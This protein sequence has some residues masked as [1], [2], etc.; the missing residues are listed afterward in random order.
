MFSGLLLILIIVALFVAKR[1]N[2]K[3]DAAAGEIARVRAALDALARRVWRADEAPAPVAAE[4]SPPPPPAPEPAPVVVA[5]PPEPIPEPVAA[6][7]A[8]PEPVA[9]F[10]AT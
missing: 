5:P 8:T 1:A 6:F 3:A 9:A 2:D 7:E 4:P 10:E